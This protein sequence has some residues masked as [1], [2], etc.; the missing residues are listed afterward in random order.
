M[1]EREGRISSI[2]EGQAEILL[3]IV[4]AVAR[5]AWIMDEDGR[6]VVITLYMYTEF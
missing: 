6:L 3:Q 1:V 4:R 5:A 2:S